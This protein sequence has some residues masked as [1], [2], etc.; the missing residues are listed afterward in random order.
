MFHVTCF[1]FHETKKT[2]F[3]IFIVYLAVILLLYSPALTA[4][5][6]SDDFDWVNRVK[7]LSPL[8]HNYFLTNADGARASGVYR[9][10]TIISFWAN[11]WLADLDSSFF[12]LFSV[13]LHALNAFLVFY[14]LKLIL[15][16]ACSVGEPACSV[17]RSDVAAIIAGLFFAVLPNHSEAVSWISGRGDVLATFFYL[18]AAILYIAFR[19]KGGGWRL[20]VSLGCFLLALFSKEMAITLPAILLAYEAIWQIRQIK[21]VIVYLL[22]F[23]VVLAGYFVLRFFA[24]GLF[25]GF[26]GNSNLNFSFQRAWEMLGG[27]WLSN[28]LNGAQVLV[29]WPVLPLAVISLCILIGALLHTEAR[30]AYIFGA[31]FF[32]LTLAPVVYLQL[33]HLTGE[34]ERFI[35]LPSVGFSILVAILMGDLLG[36][37]SKAFLPISVALVV[38]I[39]FSWM[40]WNKN[41]NWQ[42]A[43]ELSRSLL[44]NFG[45]TV[46]L[47]KPNQGVVIL[48]LP[49]NFRGAQVFRNGWLAALDLYYPFYA[50]DLLTVKAGLNITS[51]GDAAAISWQTTTDGFVGESAQPIFYGTKNLESLDYQMMIK[52]Y[53][54]DILSGSAIELNFTPQFRKQNENKAMIF[55]V[56]RGGRFEKLRPF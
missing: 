2:S 50:P 36:R 8:T 24:T 10:L 18:L 44:F 23:F 38:S 15:K 30:R 31:I 39:Y 34:G 11:Y 32:V 45:Q 33:D 21:Q 6:V 52:N 7:S 5:F 25:Y 43:G 55:L 41:I 12:H 20:A 19:Q 22:P 51:D 28:F 1:M 4:F 40:L 47:T 9:P 56:M 26:Y 3:L 29:Y 46:D 53:Q 35:Y 54:K 14:F 27:G 49:D 42:R 17:G 13:I 37:K 16:P 48:G